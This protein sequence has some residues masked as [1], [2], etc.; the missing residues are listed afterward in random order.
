MSLRSLLKG[1]SFT[2]S[3]LSFFIENSDIL[4]K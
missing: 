3:S 4:D 2:L 1:T